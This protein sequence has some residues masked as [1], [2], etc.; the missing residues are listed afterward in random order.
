VFTALNGA[1][2]TAAMTDSRPEDDLLATMRILGDCPAAGC[3]NAPPT[4]PANPCPLSD[5]GVPG[6]PAPLCTTPTFAEPYFYSFSLGY[7]GW[8]GPGTQILESVLGT[9]GGTKTTPVGFALPG[10]ADPFS[11]SVVPATTEVFPVGESPLILIANRTNAN[12]LGQIIGSFPA[13]GAPGTDL[14]VCTSNGA[15]TSDGSY[16]VR[17]IWD[18]HPYPPVA[19]TFPSTTAPVVGF[20]AGPNAGLGSECKITRRPLGNLFAG[21]FCETASTAFTW[22]LDPALEG[23]RGGIANAGNNYLGGPASNVPVNLILREPLSGTYQT[24][25]FDEVRRFGGPLGSHTNS[26]TAY[27]KPPYISQEENIQISAGAQFNPE[28]F[29]CTP[30]AGD[31]LN[32]GGFRY[33]AIGTSDEVEAVSVKADTIGYIFFSFGNVSS[34]AQNKTGNSYGYL[35]INGIDPVFADYENNAGNP[36]QPASPTSPLTWGDLPFCTPGGVPSCQASAIWNGG[37][38]YPNLRNGTYPAWAELRLICDTADVRCKVTTD[39]FGAESLVANLQQDIHF[40]HAGGV[41]DLLPFDDANAWTVTGY[42]D[43]EYI[44]DHYSYIPADDTQNYNNGP[45]AIYNNASTQTTH[46]AL[47]APGVGLPLSTTPSCAGGTVGVNGPPDAECGGD[48]GG[49]VYPVG[50]TNKGGQLQ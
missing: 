41:P 38:S 27:G 36:G 30:G 40:N 18:Q 6:G 15:Y 43:V 1:L 35:T 13:C 2:I 28:G 39:P 5:V 8:P 45:D 23:T 33:R 31:V 17:N 14:V 21:N 37:L 16:Y 11:S 7:G 32:G 9:N 20:C 34:I 26:G 50:T 12:G 19:N 3:G 42:G 29:Q 25:E 10:F 48:A 24:F 47:L 4:P 44:R 46:Q 22:P 49:F